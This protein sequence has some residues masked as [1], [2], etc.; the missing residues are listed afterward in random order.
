MQNLKI[1]TFL[2]T[3]ANAVRTQIWTALIA[4][5]LLKNLQLRATFGWSPSNLAVLLRYQLFAYRN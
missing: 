2:G 3:T 5:L 1:K 4:I